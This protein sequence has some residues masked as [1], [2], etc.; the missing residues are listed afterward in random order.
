LARE[1]RGAMQQGLVWVKDGDLADFFRRRQP[2]I[3]HV[4]YAGQRKSQT[5]EHG[6]AEGRRIVLH[7]GVKA[8]EGTSAYSQSAGAPSKLLHFLANS[9]ALKYF[10]SFQ[11]ASLRPVRFRGIGLLEAAV[12]LA[13]GVQ[14]HAG[15]AL[16]LLHAVDGGGNG[17]AF[18]A[19]DL[20]GRSALVR[21]H[22]IAA[23]ERFVLAVG[24]LGEE[25]DFTQ[26][27]H[28]KLGA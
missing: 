9:I 1:Q 17:R 18:D 24:E 10:E 3:R 11:V 14:F 26:R 28:T 27:V 12:G 4:R 21:S 7:K 19:R 25:R 22:E 16:V 2:H 23:V 15:R 13:R 8:A 5:F 20:D 6:R